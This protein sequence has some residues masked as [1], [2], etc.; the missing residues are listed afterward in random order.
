MTLRTLKE[1]VDAFLGELVPLPT[2][3]TMQLPQNSAR[4]EQVSPEPL[5]IQP[6]IEV[7][8]KSNATPVGEAKMSR[9]TKPVPVRPVKRATVVQQR[10]NNAQQLRESIIISEILGPP[11]S[12][13]H[14]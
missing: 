13:R 3:R 2:A 1:Q 8:P 14:K 10:L 5:R 7:A 9:D 11:L 6:Q 4:V 12:R